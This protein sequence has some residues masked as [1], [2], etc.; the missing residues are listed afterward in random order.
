MGRSSR[1]SGVAEPTEAD[2]AAAPATA[3]PPATAAGPPAGAG[4]DTGG[5]PPLE[6]RSLRALATLHLKRTLD[7]FV[8]DHGRRP[9]PDEA[10]Q[11]LKVAVKMRDDYGAAARYRPRTAPGAAAPG[12][13]AEP[14]DADAAPAAAAEP[15]SATAKAIDAA[16]AAAAAPAAAAPPGSALALA[17]PSARAGL[18]PAAR[19]AL[20]SAALVPTAD[21]GARE[22][23]PSA[24][25]ARRAAAR[26]PRPEW[27]A[28][29]RAYR[30]IS[31]HAGWVR[32]VA[33]D[34]GNE[35]FAT[36]SGDRTI[37]VWETASG[38]LK[39]TL[40]GHIEQVTALAVSARRPYMFSA[41]LD[42]MVKCWDLE[43]NKV[44]RARRGV[45]WAAANAYGSVERIRRPAGR[46]TDRR[47]RPARHP[48]PAPS[49]DRRLRPPQV[50][51]QYHGH[52]S[53]VYCAALHPT[54]DVLA[55][56]GRDATCRVWDV[57]SRAQAFAL[58]GHGDTV[59]AVVCQATDPQI[60]TASHDKTVRLWDLRTGKTLSTLTY[61]KKAVRALAA[62]PAD[63][64]FASGGADNIK[65]FRLP[66]GEFLH[67]T[68][69]PQRAIVNAL[70][71][72]EDGVMASG[73]D[74]GSLCFWDWRSGNRFQEAQS[75]VQPGS[76]EA[77]AGIYAMAFDVTGT[78][79]VTCEA[80][81]TV[82]M[83]KEDENATPASHPIDF[84]PP[85]G[86]DVKRY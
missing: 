84:R 60:I 46:P 37:K 7:M 35:W 6:P 33:F 82:K 72:N 30:V 44:R 86:K 8:G 85:S 5:L 40:T 12:R 54:L 13:G 26:W 23:A 41:G 75:I 53:G 70:A 3:A 39:L 22:Y 20:A 64:A 47:R 79:L 67:N 55:T 31:G 43:Q 74:N 42:K 4:A 83:W 56:G 77:E 62:H 81:K 49:N 34:P 57:R 16:A 69:Q 71:V 59:A 18:T 28:P 45:R 11:R 17:G 1:A 66:E 19:A 65:K 36:G 25:V 32:S 76:L 29:W 50:T 24:Q 48:P 78:R 61:H 14:A 9:P 21:G 10:A 80:D 51:R 58:G 52:L 2:A 27:H 38:T 68:L 63:H 15:R 73:G